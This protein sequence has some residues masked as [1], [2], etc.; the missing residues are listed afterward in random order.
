MPPQV[1]P[2]DHSVEDQFSILKRQLTSFISRNSDKSMSLDTG[3]SPIPSGPH[4]II[5][6]TKIHLNAPSDNTH[7]IEDIIQKL[8]DPQVIQTLKQNLRLPNKKK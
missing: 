1:A 3:S 5:E 7:G 2:L 4:I 8:G 6:N